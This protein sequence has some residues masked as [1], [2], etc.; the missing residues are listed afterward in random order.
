MRICSVVLLAFVIAVMSLTAFGS[1]STEADVQRALIALTPAHWQE[2]MSAFALG[3]ERGQITI[4]VAYRLVNRLSA[5]QGNQGDKEQI[6]MTIG[7]A[8]QDDLPVEM[9]IEK[10]EEG[11]A[12]GAPLS[13]I[14]MGSMGQPPIL[15]LAQRVELME[16]TR[17]MLYTRRIFSAPPGAKA[18][19]QSLPIARFNILVNEIADVLADYVESGGSPVQ[20]YLLYQQVSERLTNLANL[21]APIVPL[22]DAQLVLERVTA[23]DLSSI[24]E[25]IYQREGQ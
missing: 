7:R 9:L 2:I 10:T 14:L 20:G 16:A 24:V 17:D 25:K 8:L 18:A 19:T 23:T 21:K 13:L 5:Y 4:P 15:G 3:F 12:R 6:L 1:Q 22:A 11:M